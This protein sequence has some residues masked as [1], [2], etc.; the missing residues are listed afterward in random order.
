MDLLR[1]SFNFRLDEIIHVKTKIIAAKEKRSMNA[2][3]EYFIMK[4]VEA[5]EKE[6]GNIEIPIEE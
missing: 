2:Q 4:G 1:A 3:L 6:N 5:Y